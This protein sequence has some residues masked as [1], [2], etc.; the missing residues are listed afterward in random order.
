VF[1]AGRWSVAR[2]VRHTAIRPTV[3][4]TVGSITCGYSGGSIEDDSHRVRHST[5]PACRPPSAVGH[6]TWICPGLGV[7]R[8]IG[9]SCPGLFSC[10]KAQLPNWGAAATVRCRCCDRDW[11]EGV[12]YFTR[13]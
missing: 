6:T 7:R 1:T 3:S 4:A 9:R 11:A 10:R 8:G 13:Y 12:I 2:I 5:Y